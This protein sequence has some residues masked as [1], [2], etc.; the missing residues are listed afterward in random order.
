MNHAAS[1]GEVSLRPNAIGTYVTPSSYFGS[2][3]PSH[4]M[5]A[6]MTLTTYKG[7]YPRGTECCSRIATHS[8][9]EAETIVQSWNRQGFRYWIV[10]SERIPSGGL[11][12]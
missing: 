2:L 9:P 7:V 12:E 3:R 8:E 6:G 4:P 11:A 1:W 5:L 10:S